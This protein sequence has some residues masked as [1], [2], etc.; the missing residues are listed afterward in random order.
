MTL[1][2]VDS[3]RDTTRIGA[4]FSHYHVLLP[5]LGVGHNRLIL[6]PLG[7]DEVV[8]RRVIS[9]DLWESRPPETPEV[10]IPIWNR[11]IF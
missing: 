11:E 5:P 3:D 7:Q 10:T 2:I 4:G 8:S 9:G 6:H 1:A